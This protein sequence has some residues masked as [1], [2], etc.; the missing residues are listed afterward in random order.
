MICLSLLRENDVIV[1]L[2]EIH[3]FVTLTSFD[4]QNNVTCTL[5]LLNID[6]S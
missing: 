1:Y 6:G 3:Y 2:I 5:T 4:H